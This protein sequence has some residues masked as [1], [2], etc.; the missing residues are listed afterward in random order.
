MDYKNLEIWKECR[1]LTSTIYQITKTFP[2][3][4]LFGIVNQMRRCAVSITSIAEG[5]GRPTSKGTLSFLYI[6]R[7]SL[8]EIESQ[9]YISLDLEYISKE[10]FD[11]I[12][13]Q[14]QKCKKLLNGFINYY[15]KYLSKNEE[16]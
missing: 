14:I 12:D 16:L 1:V 11:E 7:G 3:D 5:C 10:K 9:M 8:F 15:K 13:N 6:A 4:E 2:K